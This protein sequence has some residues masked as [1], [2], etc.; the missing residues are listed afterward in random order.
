MISNALFGLHSSGRRWCERLADSLREMSFTPCK[1]EPDIW[2]RRKGDLYEYF[3]SSVD[4]L[5][6]AAKNPK[7]I[8]GEL[9]NKHKF[10]LKGTGPIT[11]H[12]GCDFNR[13]DDGAV[14]KIH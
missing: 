7:E 13:N 8:V 1:V 12:L 11:F 4:N 3:G 2:M 9:Q 6:N 5:A 10:N 14:P